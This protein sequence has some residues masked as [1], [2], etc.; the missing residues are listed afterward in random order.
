MAGFVCF[1]IFFSGQ[2]TSPPEPPFIDKISRYSPLTVKGLSASKCDGNRLLTYLQADEFKISP[3]KYFIFNVK[4][5]NEVTFSNVR[6]ETHYYPDMHGTTG[7]ISFILSEDETISVKGDNNLDGFGVLTRGIVK[8]LVWEIFNADK[9]CLRVKAKKAHI[10]FNKNRTSLENVTLEQ[11]SPRR[12]IL[13]RKVIWNGKDQVFQIPGNYIVLT[14]EGKVTGKGT[15]IN[16]D[17]VV[18]PFS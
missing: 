11:M 8:D 5:F 16:V 18:S 3:R 6:F 1:I 2:K 10:D 7:G 12:T 4:P 13:S 14:P 15:K 9:L 17:F